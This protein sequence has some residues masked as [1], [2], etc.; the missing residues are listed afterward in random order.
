MEK[1]SLF[2]WDFAKTNRPYELIS[3]R[4]PETRKFHKSSKRERQLLSA[5]TSRKWVQYLETGR[6]TSVERSRRATGNWKIPR[7][8]ETRKATSYVTKFRP[9]TSLDEGGWLNL[10]IFL[11]ISGLHLD[12]IKLPRDW[13]IR[14]QALTPPFNAN[15]LKYAAREGERRMLLIFSFELVP[16]SVVDKFNNCAKII[17]NAVYSKLEEFNLNLISSYSLYNLYTLIY[18]Q[19]F[20]WMNIAA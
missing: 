1:R 16:E 14:Q 13:N 7:P 19:S 20:I 11:L 2:S 17:L 10:C 6:N 3:P 9:S 12:E 18:I 4:S 8:R 5:C 15:N